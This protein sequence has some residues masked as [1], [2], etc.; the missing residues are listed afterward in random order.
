MNALPFATPLI[1]APIA[2]P[3]T[4]ELT[5][6]VCNAGGFGIHPCAY[7]APDE[8]LRDAARIRELTDR[9]FGVNLFIEEPLA[10]IADD[11]LQAAHERLRPYYEEL[12]ADFPAQPT[13]PPDRYNAQVE[14]M[15]SIAPAV[16][17]FTFGIPKPDVLQRIKRAGIYTIGTA[18]TVQEAVAIEEAGVDAVCAQGAEAGGH[19][20]SFLVSGDRAQIGTLALVRQIVRSVSIPVIAAGGIADSAGIAA[21]LAL[22]AAAAQCGTAFLLADEARTSLPYRTAL[23]RASSA[24]TMLTSA[25]SGRYARG[26]RNRFSIEM[27]DER[28]QAPYPYQNALTRDLR[29]KAAA[30]GNAEMLNLWAG[31]A[32]PLAQAA[33]AAEIVRALLERYPL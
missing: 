3:G 1:L 17:S 9:P 19:R 5:A 7:S 27:N 33:P 6:S 26:I 29:I 20:G 10:P 16:F 25:F 8:M 11:V 21:V 32:F 2:G 23:Q 18:T 13:R 12:E 28:L 31:Q 22:G 15:L 30:A 14:T 24:D 4:P